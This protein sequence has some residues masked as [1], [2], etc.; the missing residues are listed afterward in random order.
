[1]RVGF[2]S[3]SDFGTSSPMIT[4]STVSTTRTVM[5][6]EEAAV[7]L[8]SPAHDSSSGA[9]TGA[10]CGLSVGAEDQAGERDPDL[11]DRDVAVEAHR[12]LDD[13]QQPRREALPS[14]ASRRSRLRLTPT[15][16]NSAATYNAVSRMS[17]AMIA[18]ARSIH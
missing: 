13:R 9:T 8:S 15:A 4:A 18:H 1:M 10:S 11:R 3:A 6:A 14:S 17:R 2:W 12:V 7:A 5:P 16:A